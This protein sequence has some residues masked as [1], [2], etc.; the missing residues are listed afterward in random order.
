MRRSAMVL[1]MAFF[2]YCKIKH[3]VMDKPKLYALLVSQP[4]RNGKAAFEKVGEFV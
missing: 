4:H 3:T 1:L 2:F